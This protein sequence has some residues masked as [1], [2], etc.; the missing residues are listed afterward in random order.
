M[1]FGEV[2]GLIIV[3][4]PVLRYLIIT[5]VVFFRPPAGGYTFLFSPLCAGVEICCRNGGDDFWPEYIGVSIG[6]TWYV[7]PFVRDSYLITQLACWYDAVQYSD[8]T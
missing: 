4:P 1:N 3:K 5:V 7:D 6:W 2:R 8:L